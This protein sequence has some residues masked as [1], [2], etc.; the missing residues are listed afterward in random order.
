M[1]KIHGKFG[2]FHKNPCCLYYALTSIAEL[3]RVA[4]T[5]LNSTV[6]KEDELAENRTGSKLTIITDFNA[7]SINIFIT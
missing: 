6:K 3:K 7:L 5:G 1:L 4:K 2:I